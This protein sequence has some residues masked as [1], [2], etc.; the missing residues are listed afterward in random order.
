MKKRIFISAL[1]MASA[2]CMTACSGAPTPDRP[3]TETSSVTSADNSVQNSSEDESYIPEK[4]AD[5]YAIEAVPV[6]DAQGASVTD[7]AGNA[8]TELNIVDEKGAVITDA[9]GNKAKPN[10]PSKP[11]VAASPSAGNNQNGASGEVT[12]AQKEIP[13]ISFLW[14]G[15]AKKEGN[16]VVYKSISSDTDVMEV[17]FKVKDNAKDGTYEIS[18]FSDPRHSTTFCNKD[19]SSIDVTCCNGTVGINTEVTETAVPENKC[20]F[21]ISGASAKPG[22]EIKIICS[23]KNV[24]EPVVAF[25]SS[26]SYDADVLEPVAVKKIGFIAENGDFTSNIK[27]KG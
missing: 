17:T 18:C 6:T 21:V 2:L 1:L 23:L 5:G 10:L 8:V 14:L 20:S 4:D 9:S 11:P 24:S 27:A 7:A 13:L 26:L 3:D 25:N 12:E 16:D 22:D 15:D 19:V